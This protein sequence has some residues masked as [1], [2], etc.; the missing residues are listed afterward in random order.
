MSCRLASRLRSLLTQSALLSLSPHSIRI[1]E[2]SFI[3][4]QNFRIEWVFSSCLLCTILPREA[5][6]KFQKPG[7][8]GLAAIQGRCPCPQKRAGTRGSLRSHPTPTTLGFSAVGNQLCC[9][10]ERGSTGRSNNA[11]ERTASA[12]LTLCQ[13]KD[14]SCRP[15]W[16][17]H[18]CPAELKA[19]EVPPEQVEQVPHAFGKPQAA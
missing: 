9:V 12:E 15:A 10:K 18:F 13:G 4:F 3:L 11:R 7:W 6:W 17:G 14:V 8:T 2:S 1:G 16:S 19:P 5:V